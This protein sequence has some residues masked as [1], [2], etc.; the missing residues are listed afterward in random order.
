MQTIPSLALL[1]FLAAMPCEAQMA[2]EV[3]SPV[4]DFGLDITWPREGEQNVYVG[5]PF[6]LRITPRDSLSNPVDGVFRVR[7]TAR[8][9]GEFDPSSRGYFEHQFEIHGTTTLLLVPNFARDSGTEQQWLL[10]YLDGDVEV[11]GRSPVFS[12]LP[13]APSPFMLTYPPRHTEIRTHG[14]TDELEEQPDGRNR[15]PRI[16]TLRCV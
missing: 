8:F 16:R 14:R 15:H 6:E 13:H 9:P 7:L 1:L 10:A 4:R 5:R 3:C 12:V 11:S 2:G